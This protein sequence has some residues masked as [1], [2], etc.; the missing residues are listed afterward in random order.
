MNRRKL[1]SLIPGLALFAAIPVAFGKAKRLCLPNPKDFD[2]SKIVIG[3]VYSYTGDHE[4]YGGT[5]RNDKLYYLAPRFGS[6]VEP[7]KGMGK[8]WA[9]VDH[10]TSEHIAFIQEKDIAADF[11]FIRK[12]PS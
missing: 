7:V 4:W 2:P 1:L 5:F 12:E 9:I 11:L 8:V 10:K 3:A 6:F